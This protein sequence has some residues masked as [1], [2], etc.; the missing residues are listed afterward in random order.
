METSS[1]T[2]QRVEHSADRRVRELYRYYQHASLSSNTSSFLPAG[3]SIPSIN[4]T[5]FSSLLLAADGRGNSASSTTS[6]QSAAIGPETLLLGT[7]N[8]ILAS[9]A[10]LAALRLNVEHA[11]ICVLDRDMQYIV[12][13]ATKSVIL[14][15]NSNHDSHDSPDMIWSSTTDRRAWSLC[16]VCLLDRVFAQV[17]GTHFSFSFSFSYSFDHTK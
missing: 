13:E 10:Q 9:F 17:S 11:F 8:N 3:E 2:Q 12:A 1:K 15:Y 16:Q 6:C 5:G 4:T 7:S 14:N